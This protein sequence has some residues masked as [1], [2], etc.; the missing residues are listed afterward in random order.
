MNITD[1]YSLG[2]RALMEENKVDDY[3]YL[4]YTNFVSGV[5]C[6]WC[7]KNILLKYIK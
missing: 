1:I 7:F 5:L 6:I 2:S 4:L 3:G